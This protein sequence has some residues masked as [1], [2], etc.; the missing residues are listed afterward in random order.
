MRPG[1][2][3]LSDEVRMLSEVVVKPQRVKHKIAGRKGAGGFIYIEVE[4]Y[5]A[6]GQGLAPPLK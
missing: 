2:F 1:L 6:A 4:G 3:F 5:K